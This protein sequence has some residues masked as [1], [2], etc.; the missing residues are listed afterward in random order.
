MAEP[1]TWSIGSDPASDLPVDRPSVSWRH[2]RLT[3]LS[4][5]TYAV[6]DLGSTNGTF[7]NGRP[8]YGVP[9]P[10]RRSDV[11][12][13]GL[14]VPM[15]WPAE[16]RGAP[17]GAGAAR[18]R[19]DRGR[20]VRI[21][22]D[23]DNDVVIDSPEVSARHARVLVAPGGR[24]AVVED[25]GSTNGTSVGGPDRPV[26]RATITPADVVYFGPVA[27]PAAAFFPADSAERRESIPELVFRGPVMTVGRDPSCNLVVDFPVVSSRH[28]R[29]VRSGGAV[30]VQDLGSSNGTFVNG[31]RVVGTETAVSGDLIG[32][33]GYLVRLVDGATVEEPEGEKTIAGPHAPETAPTGPYPPPAP[34]LVPAP[35][36]ERP[37]APVL[38]GEAVGGRAVVA[39]GIALGAQAGVIAEAV[40][41]A[42]GRSP[43]GALFGLGVSAVWFGMTSALFERLLD[44]AAT[45]ADPRRVRRGLAADLGRSLG[46]SALFD[47]FFCAVLMGITSVRMPF[48]GGRALAFA[49]IWLAALVGSALGMALTRLAGRLVLGLAAAVV[50]TVLMTVAGGSNRPPSRLDPVSRVVTSALPAR[51]AFESLLLAWA[52]PRADDPDD[53]PVEPYFPA[54]TDRAGSAACLTALAAMFGGAVY[55]DAFIALALAARRPRPGPAAG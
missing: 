27:Y 49:T 53:D 55:A 5:G 42:A 30:L 28:A 26:P 8:V 6:E 11:V 32:L 31:T 13:L 38:A 20:V 43:E 12:T 47:L 29:F 17:A 48:A 24:E 52:G 54:E 19:P 15:P 23:P 46:R 41:I 36:P 40:V 14:S 18:G 50:L 25:L 35:A 34:A 2:C 39:A 21:G 33:G 7:V 44:A 10:V 9:T 51:W 22:R 37:A 4:D 3:R 1:S 16:P 45:H